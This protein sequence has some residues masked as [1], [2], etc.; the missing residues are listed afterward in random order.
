MPVGGPYDPVTMVRAGVMAVMATSVLAGCGASD[1]E[2]AADTV[3]SYLEAVVDG[4]G[5][6]AC[7]QLTDAVQRRIVDRFSEGAP[8]AGI[9]S[10]E[11]AI[12]AV[13]AYVRSTELAEPV[14]IKVERVTV[15]GDSATVRMRGATED[16]ELTKTDNAGWLIS[17]GIF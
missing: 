1:E 11:Q 5:Q 10:C 13:I 6:R 9:T 8:S 4:N 12:G 15:D 2:Q 16:A 14:E 17:G 3:R 7:E